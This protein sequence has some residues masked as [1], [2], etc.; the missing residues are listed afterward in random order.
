MAAPKSKNDTQ[1]E[2]LRLA[3]ADRYVKGETQ[4]SI[5]AAL[6]VVQS[7][8]SYHLTVIEARWQRQYAD[9]L[10]AAKWAQLAKVDELERTYWQAWADS[11]QAL[12]RQTQYADVADPKSPAR[13]TRAVQTTEERSGDPRWLAGVQWCIETRCKILGL[14]APERKDLTSNGETIKIYQGVDPDGV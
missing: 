7:A 5:A 4:A 2:A 8:V 6:G 1:A 12:T 10:D 14:W 3:I 9:K 11:R 13:P